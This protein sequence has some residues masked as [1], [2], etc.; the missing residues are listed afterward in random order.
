MLVNICVG[1]PVFG[2]NE[3]WNIDL[4]MLCQHTYWLT[5]LKNK[6][7]DISFDN[8]FDISD[9]LYQY[10]F[11]NSLLKCQSYQKENSFNS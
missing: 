7:S 8:T 10:I 2:N 11:Y 4:C 9:V 3:H 1:M 6:T 5:P